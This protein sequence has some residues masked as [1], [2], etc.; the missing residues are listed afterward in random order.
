MHPFDLDYTQQQEMQLEIGHKRIKKLLFSAAY[1][2][3]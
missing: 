3:Q 1:I 2:V